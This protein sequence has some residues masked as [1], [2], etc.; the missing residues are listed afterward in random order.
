MNIGNEK[1]VLIALDC[2]PIYLFLTPNSR[3]VF[4]A[5]VSLNIHSFIHSFIHALDCVLTVCLLWFG[6]FASF[7]FCSLACCSS[8]LRRS[9]SISLA[10]CLSADKISASQHFSFKLLLKDKHNTFVY[11]TQHTNKK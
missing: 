6:V 9:Y 11:Q 5:G 4:C 7:C 2:L 10:S 3:S 1:I 8:N